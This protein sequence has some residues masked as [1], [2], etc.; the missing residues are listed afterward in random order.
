MRFLSA[1]SIFRL[2]AGGTFALSALF[3]LGCSE[4]KRE[5]LPDLPPVELPEGVPGSYSGTMPCDDCKGK[6]VRLTLKEDMSAEAVQSTLRETV[7]VDTLKGSYVVTDSTVK[8]TLSGNG[9]HWNFKR[10]GSGNL[11]FLT[12]AGTVYVNENGLPADFI[13]IYKPLAPVKE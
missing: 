6:M 13:K 1:C 12:S 4:E 9:I 5:P 2:I 11:S 3:T 10:I 7:T 8:V